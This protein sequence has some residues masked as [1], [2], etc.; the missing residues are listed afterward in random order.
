MTETKLDWFKQRG[1]KN[2]KKAVPRDEYE[3]DSLFMGIAREVSHMSKCSSRQ[4]GAVLVK[5]HNVIS[6]GF[7]GSPMGSN[8]CQNSKAECPR[9]QLDIP[10]GQ[11]LEVCP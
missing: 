3:W 2:N 1:F 5:D 9:K 7:N 8:L 6:I 10:S 11:N 4:I